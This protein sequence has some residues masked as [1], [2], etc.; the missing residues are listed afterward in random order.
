M[1]GRPLEKYRSKR[2]FTRTAEP[3]GG[4]RVAASKRLR[5]V[6][7]KHAA[8]R[9]HYDLRL[10][11]DG[12]F[13]SWAVT[14]GPS[15][16]PADKRLAVQVE[17]H[18]LE[19]GDFEGTIPQGEYGGGT[20][21]LWDRGYWHPDDDRDPREAL[22]AGHLK[23]TLEGERLAGS[24]ALVRLKA[25]RAS[26][27]NPS[28]LLIK[29]R[30]AAARP[31]AGAG[32]LEEDRSVASDR[33]MEAI[34]AG[35]GSGPRPF[36]LRGVRRA[37]AR[38]VWN[39][40]HDD[41]AGPTPA[42][43]KAKAQTARAARPRG[44]AG[45]RMPPFIEPELCKLAEVPPR[46]GRWVHE[47][48]LD[49]YRLQLRVEGGVAQLR[50]RRGLD[51]T[52]KFAAVAAAARELPDCLIDGEA[53]ALDSAGHPDF[54]ALQSALSE[55]R[56]RDIVYF[57][58]DLLFLE[59][60]DLRARPLLERKQLLQQ[61]LVSGSR[62]LRAQIRYLDH[63][64]SP[65]DEVLSSACRMQLEGI[66]SKRPDLAYYSGRNGDWIKTKCRG[67]QE[68]VI[69]GWTSRGRALSSLIVGVFRDGE[70]V[71]AG[72]VGT[73][74]SAG[75]IS[76]LLP[77]L[78]ELGCERSPFRER[79]H[80]PGERQIHWVKPRLVAEIEFAGW[81]E[82]G[83]VRQASYKGLREDKRATEV[84]AEKAGTAAVPAREAKP[85]PPG[86]A[87]EP[88]V[89]RAGST[90]SRSGRA[91]AKHAHGTVLGVAITHPDKLLWPGSGGEPG[92]SKRELAEYYAAVADWMLPHIRGRPCSII[93]APDGIGGQKF[94]QRHGMAGMS[95][96]I[97]L[98]SVAGD[99]KPYV[100]IDTDAALVAAAQTGA[101]ELHPW[102]CTPGHPDIPGRLV[103]DFDPA[104][105]VSFDVVIGAA[106]EM[107]QRLAVL[108]LESFCKTTGGKGLHVVTPLEQPRT[109][110]DWPIV[111]A[112]A[113][114][115]CRRIAADS[116]ER[117]LI[118]MTKS[119]RKGRIFLDYLRND[120]MSTAVAVL[121][122][123]ARPGAPVSM[124]LTWSQV[125][126][127]LDPQRFTLRTVVR[128][129][130]RSEAWAEYGQAARPIVRAI[131]RLTGSAASRA[132]R[133]AG[134]A[135]SAG[136]LR[137]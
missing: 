101:V 123:R 67:G 55:G 44:A 57:A 29:H 133:G 91:A 52:E 90:K 68:V 87:P 48:K 83:S 119:A 19:Y 130:A 15:L 22:A 121:S 97:T 30:D 129:I 136:G 2:D 124:P 72:R 137:P 42:R 110:L 7:Q 89:P 113:R 85:A 132:G 56:S 32:I 45:R 61:T 118:T 18:P 81:T 38:A 117:Y 120:R 131:E 49:G 126:S 10:E 5:F 125:R 23:F 14:R 114:E 115:L 60:K 8:R 34:A 127:G 35:I 54:A 25:D 11:L 46:E 128:L 107:R 112:F 100:Q 111:K 88:R 31:G 12:V 86:G 99:R 4:G 96:L 41:V 109:P 94:F 66:I 70:L 20:V 73:G 63:V 21:Q 74:F 27:R 122:P 28:W 9:L 33:A 93:R 50:T 39:S 43:S 62:A 105:D 108:G 80:V 47:I 1:A 16:D 116:P 6:I 76:T 92:I 95:K 135:R 17:D 13:R 102:N 134:S 98:V 40:G 53:V 24:W 37:S 58:F 26:G 77:R 79:V 64:E 51:W 3:S 106:Q 84:V 71:P 59:G 82:G 36:M 75:K 103:F 69:G 65:G 104:P 78:R